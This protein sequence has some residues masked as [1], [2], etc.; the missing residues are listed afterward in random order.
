M[1]AHI[2]AEENVKLRGILQV[3]A[4]VV[5]SAT[6]NHL[7]KSSH[8]ASVATEADNFLPRSADARCCP[9]SCRRD[10]LTCATELIGAKTSKVRED[11]RREIYVNSIKLDLLSVATLNATRHRADQRSRTCSSICNISVYHAK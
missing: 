3:K 7:V 6:S 1:G 2:S 8:S 9:V 11:D 10:V 4:D 5:H